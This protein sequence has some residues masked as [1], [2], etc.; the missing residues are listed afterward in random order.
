[1]ASPNKTAQIMTK[2]KNALKP[3]TGTKYTKRNPRKP[4]HKR[5]EPLEIPVNMDS[6][7]AIAQRRNCSLEEAKNVL[8]YALQNLW[9][10][11]KGSVL[12]TIL[13]NRHLYFGIVDEPEIKDL[14]YNEADLV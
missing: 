12:D 7:I 8:R 10:L 4:L 11:E 14:E 9:A 13:L 5:K 3:L 6:L 1:M 2:I